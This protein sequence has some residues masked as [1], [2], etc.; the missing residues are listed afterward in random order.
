MTKYLVP[1]VIIA[2]LFI[3][4]PASADEIVEQ[5]EAAIELYKE[6]NITEALE[7]L[8]FA[9]A[10]LRQKKGEN[11]G[12]LFPE[13]LP[14]WKAEEFESQAVGRA[15]FGGGI[16]ASRRYTKD[17]GGEA[18]IEVMS[19]SPMIQTMG[20]LL[21]NPALAGADKDTKL[22]RIN[23]QK[24]LLKTEQKDRAEVS[25]I[26]EGKVMVQVMVNGLDDAAEVAQAYA[27]KIDLKKLK[28]LTL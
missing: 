4:A 1:M 13:A 26:V 11:M 15:A 2:A 24:A 17:G 28:E 18:E 22:I 9:T 21:N 10:Q 12:D 23:R 27:K 3:A 25:F 16:T 6:G 8:D 19:D 5:L 20:M 14:G 7:E